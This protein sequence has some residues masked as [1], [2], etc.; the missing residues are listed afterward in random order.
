MK[1]IHI[2]LFTIL[3]NF[4][5]NNKNYSINSCGSKGI[6]NTYNSPQNKSDCKDENEKNCKFVNITKDDYTKTFCAVIHGTYDDEMI[7]EVKEMINV[8]SIE[9]ESSEFYSTKFNKF[10]FIFFYL[11]ILLF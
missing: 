8:S 6:F 1:F 4:I 9:I 2:T 10:I 5:I 11:L 3:F 7:K